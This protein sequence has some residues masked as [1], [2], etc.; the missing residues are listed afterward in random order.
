M[1]RRGINRRRPY[2]TSF[3]P[4]VIIGIEWDSSNSSPALVRLDVNGDAI[5]KDSAYF[6]AHPVFSNIVRC[7]LSVAGVA[8]F[9]TDGKGTGLTLTDD[10]VMVRIPRV[11]VKFEVSGTKYRWWISPYSA[12]GFELHPAFF[13]RGHSVSPAEQVY[14]GAYTAGANGGTTAA[15]GVTNTIAASN[16]TGLKLTSKSGVKSLTSGTVAQMETAGNLIGTGW[17]LMNF[18]TWSLMQLL[19]YVEYAHFDS[20][21]KLGQGRTNGSNTAASINGTYLDQVGEGAGA[22]VQSLLSVNGSYGDT[23]GSYRP[24]IWRGIENIF[25]NLYQFCPGYNLTDTEHHILKRDGTGT[26]S[27]DLASGSYETVTSPAPLNGTDNV[28]GTDAGAYCHGYVNGLAFDTVGILNLAF[29]PNILTGSSST[30]FCDRY[31]SHQSGLGRNGVLLVG[32]LWPNGGSAGVGYRNANYGP[33]IA[34]SSIG[35]RAEFIG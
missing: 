18:W 26:I 25:G 27:G 11:Y 2:G 3:D 17:G 14:V 34:S 13:Q 22:D 15:N 19:F 4:S 10:Y 29:M 21:L 32:G 7:S 8:T 23:V 6:D 30:Y 33:T 9:G 20:Q 31:Y 35:G 1:S 5:T 24:A 16:W 28:S 12:P